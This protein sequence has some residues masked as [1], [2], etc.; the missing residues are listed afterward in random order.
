MKKPTKPTAAALKSRPGAPINS[1]GF[2]TDG[3]TLE[4]FIKK[5]YTQD[6]YPP[7][8]YV[9]NTVP[10][11]VYDGESEQ[12]PAADETAPTP[13][14]EVAL[15]SP[16]PSED[17]LVEDAKELLAATS[18]DPEPTPEPEPALPVA[19]KYYEAHN[20]N[21]LIKGK[22]GLM[23]QFSPYAHTAGTWMG[24]FA[25]DKANEIAALDELVAS[26]KSAVYALT[27]LEY[28]N[29]VKKKAVT[30]QGLGTSLIH[31]EVSD[32]P[33]PSVNHAVPLNP[34]PNPADQASPVVEGVD[35]LQLGNT[36][37]ADEPA[38]PPA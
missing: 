28:S 14:A 12:S 1:E 8:G 37:M 24:L 6:A 25:T 38:A 19:K 23:F 9:V 31:S 36:K 15:V 2:W 3:P 33:L 26:G 17:S 29:C 21:R 4:E 22:D 10:N 7:A 30:L 34:E 5:G 27:E 20:S 35:S 18:E 32:S 16:A 11:P 13:V